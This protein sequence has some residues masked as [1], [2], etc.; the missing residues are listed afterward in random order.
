MAQPVESA[1]HGGK[2]DQQDIGRSGSDKPSFFLLW[3]ERLWSAF[4][5]CSSSGEMLCAQRVRLL[6]ELVANSS[7]CDEAWLG[8]A[9]AL[10]AFALHPHC[11]RA[12]IFTSGLVSRRAQ[13]KTVVK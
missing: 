1:P 13:P 2:F 10:I 3:G 12:F 9:S 8:I 6:S 11:P 4:P 7:Q 5:P